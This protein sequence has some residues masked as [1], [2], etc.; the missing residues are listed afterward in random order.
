MSP[1]LVFP[2][3]INFHEY[4]QSILILSIFLKIL[5]F[6]REFFFYH[7][8]FFLSQKYESL[9]KSFHVYSI[10]HFSLNPCTIKIFHWHFTT[11]GQLDAFVGLQFLSF[12]AY[13]IRKVE[14]GL[15]SLVA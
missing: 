14:I 13:S 8:F 2:P 11:S 15:K 1:S 6:L 12:F 3:R 4:S 7:R 9:F 5:P 10:V